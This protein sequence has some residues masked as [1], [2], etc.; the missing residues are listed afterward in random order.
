MHETNG[1]AGIA[2]LQFTIPPREI[3][4]VNFLEETIADLPWVQTSELEI[5]FQPYQVIS[6]LVV[7]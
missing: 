5:P 4:S 2:L 1:S 3:R 6:I 7:P